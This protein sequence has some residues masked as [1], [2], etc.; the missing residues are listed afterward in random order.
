VLTIDYGPYQISQPQ[1]PQSVGDNETEL[2]KGS[3]RAAVR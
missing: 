1:S 2:A 3:L